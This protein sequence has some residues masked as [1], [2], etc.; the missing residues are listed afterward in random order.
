MDWYDAKGYCEWVGKRLP[1][2]AEWE[3]AARGTDGRKY[4]WGNGAA[5][6]EYA[7]MSDGCGTGGTL[8]VC[9]KSP[10]GDSPYGLCDMAG[11]VGEWV[12]DWYDGDYYEGSPANNPKGP[13]SGSYRVGRG[14]GF[15]RVSH[16]F[17]AGP[18]GVYDGTY[19]GLRCA[20][21]ID[22]CTPICDGKQCGEGGCPDQP[23]ACGT[24]TGGEACQQGLC[25]SSG[26]WPDCGEEVYIP[27]GTSWMGCNDA[28]DGECYADEYPYHEV[29]LDGYYIDRTEVTVDA[30][31]A[32]VLAGACGT[33]AA[34][35]CN[36][37]NPGKSQ[38]PVNCVSWWDA[39]EFC[40]WAGKRLP[41]EAEWEKAARG[42]DG[43]RFPW[44]N[45]DAT[46]DN[47]VMYGEGNN[48]CG[49]DSTW[50]VCSKSPAGDSPF[51]ACDMAG[52]IGEWVADW[53]DENY[54]SASPASNPQGPNSGTSR[55]RRGGSYLFTNFHFG[56]P[57]RVSSRISVDPALNGGDAGFRCAR[58]E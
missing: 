37:A 14:G 55:I 51:G 21:S 24:C 58:S 28:V 13:N 3:K 49:I 52:N 40:A 41:T 5:T 16:R 57:L 1:T 7:V 35:G 43:R 44:G 18:A 38:S 47:A 26:C 19:L 20:R 31:S 30:F 53:Y 22:P 25:V 46:C 9:S 4:P 33:P 23:D 39:E 48:G 36:W 45:E 50:D 17:V 42:T 15:L 10:A 2:E 12:D 8:P 54:Y 32:C 6:C 34:D 27:A 11:N 29:Y 56:A